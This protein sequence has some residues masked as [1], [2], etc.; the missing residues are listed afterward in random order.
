MS[1]CYWSTCTHLPV[2][3]L[4][5]WKG[6]L[7]RNISVNNIQQFR[8]KRASALLDIHALADSDMSGSFAGKTKQWCFKVFISCDD[9]IL[10]AVAM[11]GNDNDLPSDALSQ[12]ECFVCVLYR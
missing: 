1:C 8:T 3:S 7:K 12:L 11:Q 5:H 6:R 4:P 10:D 2:S 9:E